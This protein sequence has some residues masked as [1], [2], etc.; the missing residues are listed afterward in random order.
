MTERKRAEDALRQ[1]EDPYRKKLH[2]AKFAKLSDEARA[3]HQT[4][5]SARTAAQKELV[6]KTN[7]LLQI[8]PDEVL[9]SLTDADR[10]EHTRLK[11][12]LRKFDG[13]KPAALPVAMGL[14]DEVT[15]PAK[16]FLLE[17]G[18][19]AGRGAEVH[20]GFPKKT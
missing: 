3:A 19:L 11:E 8:V 1:L 6:E 4:P 17:R 5:A 2:D 15:T 9:K 16:T 12:E 18:E 10:S 20:A 7:R 14:R 13:Q